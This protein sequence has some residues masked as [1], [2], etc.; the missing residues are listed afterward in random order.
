MGR[1]FVPMLA[2]AESK[3]VLQGA[4]DFAK[5]F[6]MEVVV[7]NV[8][9]RDLILKLER[10]K[11]FVQEE[12]ALFSQSVRGNAE[13]YLVY[14]KKLGEEAGVSVREVLL[15]GNPFERIMDTVRED[16][17]AVKVICVAKKDAGDTL[18]ERMSDVERK[19]LIQSVYP[20]LVLGD[21]S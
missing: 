9:D 10:Y 11:I 15:E 6:G 13:K 19:I 2:T 16:D 1:I 8:I 17:A 5:R 14:E 20:V 4:V 21:K 7:I 12:S 3:R 18:K